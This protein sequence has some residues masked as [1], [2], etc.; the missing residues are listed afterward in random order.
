[1]Q[2]T[3]SIN[4]TTEFLDLV[5][6]ADNTTYSWTVDATDGKANGTDI[7][8]EIWSFTIKL[9]KIN[10]PPKITS[11]PPAAIQ[12]GDSYDYNITVVDEDNDTLIF[13]IIQAPDGLFLNSS[14][15]RIHWTPNAT[16][17]GNH[18]IIVRASDGHGGFDQQTFN[19]S[20]I[21]KPPPEKPRCVITYPTNSSKIGGMVTIKGTA[22]DDSSPLSLIQVRIDGANWVNANG[23]KNWTV[24]VDMGKMNNGKHKIEAR[25]FDGN[26][27]SDTATVTFSVYNPEPLVS[28]EGALW[29]VA[30]IIVLVAIGITLVTIRQSQRKRPPNGE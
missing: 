3:V 19:V 13:S 12:V 23:L 20:V 27:Y 16:D 5:D 9:P 21:P 2:G 17:I 15:G 26:L 24:A 1:M 7:P 28:V 18:T 10:H 25:A 29:W 8:T 22:V 4:S 14:S 6:L 30:I 11:T